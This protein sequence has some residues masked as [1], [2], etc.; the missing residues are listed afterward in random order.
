[1]TQNT[2]QPENEAPQIWDPLE[3]KDKTALKLKATG[4]GMVHPDTTFYTYEPQ[5]T[6]QG[7]F[8]VALTENDEF[9][10]LKN[11]EALTNH[12][13][14][15]P[16]AALLEA[17]KNL[18]T[19]HRQLLDG[20][21]ETLPA[22]EDA[23]RAFS[24]YFNIALSDSPDYHAINEGRK[25]LD[26][27]MLSAA[28]KEN[29]LQT[30][31]DEAYGGPVAY[32]TLQGDMRN[33]AVS[34]E[35]TV[36][37]RSVFD[38][39]GSDSKEAAEMKHKYDLALSMMMLGN[40]NSSGRLLDETIDKFS[41]LKFGEE[42]LSKTPASDGKSID[43]SRMK[44]PPLDEVER[45]MI[46]VRGKLTYY[47]KFREVTRN[48]EDVTGVNAETGEFLQSAAKNLKKLGDLSAAANDMDNAI[49][50]FNS[51][52]PKDDPKAAQTKLTLVGIKAK[53]SNLAQDPSYLGDA[54]SLPNQPAKDKTR[55]TT[56]AR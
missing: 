3:L 12:L 35:N 2:T 48:I 40:A 31:V 42:D 19:Q 26:K 1:M 8:R 7:N 4:S 17:D 53:L 50:S 37:T 44:P 45:T 46:E 24:V 11:P 6:A 23:K 55:E 38:K 56:P 33:L 54:L 32:E 52:A 30:R 18:G 25:G 43:E 16:I 41:K 10:F 29:Y 9:I 51:N 13:G 27:I 5:D 47:E 28:L 22:Y 34:L 39:P 49:Q 20:T 14:G 15:R 36:R 21:F